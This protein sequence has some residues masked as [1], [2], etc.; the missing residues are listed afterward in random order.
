MGAAVA[1]RL[2]S[3]AALQKASFWNSLWVVD[4]ASISV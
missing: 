1:P 3:C 4:G 2:Y